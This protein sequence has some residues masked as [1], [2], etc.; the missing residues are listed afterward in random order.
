MSVRLYKNTG[1]LVTVEVAFE[2]DAT[3]PTPT[4]TDVTA[5]VREFEIERGRQTELEQSEPGQL[6]VRLDNSDRRF[7]PF[8]TGS[9]YYPYVEPMKQVRVRALYFLTTWD[10]F[11]GYV[12]SWPQS[13]PSNVDAEVV[14]SATDAFKIFAQ[15]DLPENAWALQMRTLAPTAWYRFAEAAEA[16]VARDSSGGAYHGEY[17]G[18]P[19]LAVDGLM[20]EPGEDRS[21]VTGTA[22]RMAAPAAIMT[23]LPLSFA[24]V[25]QKSPGTDGYLMFGG[26]PN[27]FSGGALRVIVGDSSGQICAL[28]LDTWSPTAYYNLTH[29]GAM[30]ADDER[31]CVVFVFHS[32]SSGSI[33]LDGVDVSGTAYTSG[34]TAFPPEIAGGWCVGNA[35]RVGSGPFADPIDDFA[36]WDGVELVEAD[37]EALTL[38]MRGRAGETTGE[39]ME[40]LLDC[41]G[42]SST[43]RD[44][45][46]GNSTCGNAGFSGTVLDYLL[47][48]A[49]TENGQL[50]MDGAGVLVFHE[51][52]YLLTSA[53]GA[54][55]IFSDVPA[56]GYRYSGLELAPSDIHIRNTVTI[57]R[58][59][60][61][62]VIVEDVTSQTRY[63]KR[64]YSR[65]GLLHDD[66]DESLAAGEW[67]VGHYKNP[68]QR[69]QSLTVH[70]RRDPASWDFVLSAELGW[71]ITIERDPPGPGSPISH[72]AL[73]ESIHHHVS[74]DDWETTFVLSPADTQGYWLLGVSAL[75]VST[76][77]AY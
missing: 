41:I 11:R 23:G 30:V 53:T 40:W 37:A 5:Y 45:D 19:T 22:M 72:D 56:N 13:W 28:L 27:L 48:L 15:Y 74:V 64:A 50:Y 57:Q 10:L 24:A 77:L 63:Q 18:G 43:L 3:D 66:D 38:A 32:V 75:D 34:T 58:R 16:T 31:H 51:R 47:K 21:F 35:S 55:A 73:I 9:P 8:Y 12:D 69:V 42:W 61:Q 44:I 59:N 68:I 71:R 54:V 60:G 29:N 36:A 20:E 52:H 76:R 65:T 46:T 67:I 1:P 4:W 62:P 2:S 14:L 26:S 7:D 70:P 33:Y 25:F 17:E 39:R 49:E 6:H